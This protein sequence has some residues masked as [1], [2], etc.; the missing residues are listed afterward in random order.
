[1]V[2]ACLALVDEISK[3]I[4]LEQ[5]QKVN[6]NGERDLMLSMAECKDLH[7]TIASTKLALSSLSSCLTP[8]SSPPHL[9]SSP[10]SPSFSTPSPLSSECTLQTCISGI[11]HNLTTLHKII[12]QTDSNNKNKFKAFNAK[13]LK[14]FQLDFALRQKVD[15]LSALFLN[16]KVHSLISDSEGKEFWDKCFGQVC[17][18]TILG[19]VPILILRTYFAFFYSF[20]RNFLSHGKCS[21]KT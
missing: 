5:K 19:V 7:G 4:T 6:N 11:Q 17:S 20:Y 18:R 15:Q 10:D 1:M 12:T 13:R 14:M 9:H 21:Y 3:S 16:D 2:G 8:P